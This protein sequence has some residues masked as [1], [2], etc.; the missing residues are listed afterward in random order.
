MKNIFRNILTFA[1]AMIL[2]VG[3]QDSLENIKEEIVG[4]WHY[5]TV[6]S[7]VQEDVWLSISADGTF[8]LYQ[9][10]G[11]GVYWHSSGEYNLNVED[12]ILSGVYSDRYPWNYDYA[13]KVTSSTL[14]LTAVQ[15]E[16]YVQIYKREAIPAEVKE[17]TLELDTKSSDLTPKL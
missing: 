4:D 1:S 9:K 7:E 15:E 2:A 16:S 3:C 6:E 17:K 12:K 13:F 11:G 5:Q 8:D 14:T 10:I